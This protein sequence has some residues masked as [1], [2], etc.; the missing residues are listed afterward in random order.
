MDHIG[1]WQ[2][3]VGKVGAP[4]FAGTLVACLLSGKFAWLHFILMTTGIGM[5]RSATGVSTIEKLR[6]VN[7]ESIERIA[8]RAEP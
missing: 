4:I 5:M 8:E 2:E 3:F 1:F 6:P 7:R